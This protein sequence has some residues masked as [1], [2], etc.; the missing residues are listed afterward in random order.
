M[1]RW[2]RVQSWEVSIFSE[3]K[4]YFKE[5][6]QEK[7]NLKWSYFELQGGWSKDVSFFFDFRRLELV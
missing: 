3:K 6:F 4:W 5:M 2:V 1:E 7:R